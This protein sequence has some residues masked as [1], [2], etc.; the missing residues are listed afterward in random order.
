MPDI[1]AFIQWENYAGK[2]GTPCFFESTPLTFSSQQQRLHAVEPGSRLWLVSRSPGDHQYYFVGVLSIEGLKENAAESAAATEFGRY[3]VVADPLLSHDLRT[4][5]PAEGILRALQFEG[6]KPIKHGASIGQSIQAIRLLTSTDKQLLDF[7]LSRLLTGQTGLL[8]QPFGL[9]TKC[10]ETFANYFLHNWTERR[11]PMAFL[12]YDPPPG[13]PAGSPVFIHS[14]K[15][16]RLVARFRS[17][18]YLAGHKLTVDPE[19]R[20]GIREWVWRTYRAE[21][22]NPPSKD[23]YDRFWVS[24]NGIRSLFIIDNIQEAPTQRA[25]KEYGRALEWGY[26]MGVGYRYLTL[27]QSYLLL[28]CTGLTPEVAGEYC[29]PLLK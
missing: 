8:D 19:E 10:D 9:W 23:D 17:S 1:I 18:L 26:P 2:E 7:A 28:A 11:E 22:V 12:L 25:F 27:S 14:N 15:N 29:L 4:T 21:T 24:Q 20:V 5:F 3:A 16:L 13:L 6:K